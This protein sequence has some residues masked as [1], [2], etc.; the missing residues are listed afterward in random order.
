MRAD[1]APLWAVTAGDFYGTADVFNE[2]KSHFVAEMMPVL[3]YDAIGIGEMDLNFGLGVLAKDA[4]KYHLPIVCANLVARVDSVKVR[5]KGPEYDAADKMGTAFVPYHIV[6]K[7]GIRIGFIGVMSPATKQ[8]GSGASSVDALTYTL[9]DVAESIT[10]LIPEVRKQCDVLVLLAHM[11]QV[12]AQKLAEAVPGFDLIVLGHDPGN[13]PLGEPI[14]V[15]STRIVRASSQ[16]QYLG[17]MDLKLDATHHIAEARNRIYPMNAEHPDDPEMAKKL[18]QFDELNK[19]TQK[20]LYAKQ[21]LKGEAGNPFGTR[22]LGVGSCQ[23]CHEAQFQVYMK[24]AHAHAYATLASEFVNRDTNCVGCHVT[25]YNED[26]GFG[27]VRMRGA[28]VDLT[29]VQC[30]ACHGP[31]AEH[32]RDGSYRARAREAC[33]KC[34]TPNDDPDFNFDKDWPK[35]AH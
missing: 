1:A 4:R 9:Q 16:G 18:D 21:Q 11:D 8:R 12:E 2:A 33:V 29:D 24:T 25:G 15:G 13:R 5:E 20:E 3:G 34:H 19:K 35:I 22:Y 31:G 6:E 26:G 7:K 30:E 32:T 23:S 27:G 10:P 14:V 17:T 28:P